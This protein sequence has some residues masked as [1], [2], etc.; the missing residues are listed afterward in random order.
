LLLL[1]RRAANAI[2][3]AGPARRYLPANFDVYLLV[4]ILVL[5]LFRKPLLWILDPL[6]FSFKFLTVA[7]L[8]AIDT[9]LRGAFEGLS[10]PF[11]GMS[12]WTPVSDAYQRFFT[13][14]HAP[15]YADTAMFL[16]FTGVVLGLEL[17]QPRFW[18]R[19]VCPLGALARLTYK[20]HPLKRRIRP[21]C[22]YC[23]RCETACHFGGTAEDDC[24]YCM[25]C[26]D[27][28]APGKISFLPGGPVLKKQARKAAPGQPGSEAPQVEDPAAVPVAAS[29]RAAYRARVGGELAGD[30]V[31]RRLLLQY[32]VGGVVAY[33]LLRLFD[34]RRELPVDFIRP[35]GVYSLGGDEAAD[36]A[37]F[38][39]LCLKCGQCLKGCTTNGLQPVLSEAGFSAL[40]TPRLIP[41]LGYCEYSCNVCGQVCPSGA[42][43]R[44][45]VEEKKRQVL[46]TAYF[47]H[48]RCIPFVTPHN[49][50]VCEEHCPT[51]DKAIK[52]REAA[53][54]YWPPDKPAWNAG[55]QAVPVR[56]LQ[57][58]VDPSLC[59]GCGICEKV[60]PL[61]GEGAVRVLR[62]P[63]G[64]AYETVYETGAAQGAGAATPPDGA[65]GGSIGG[66]YPPGG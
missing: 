20:L 28:C 41:R 48:S 5:A 43:P 24:L 62:L 12:W 60:C 17:L 32:A 2:K 21:D 65:G 8:P 29:A 56:T 37:R 38:T 1:G 11:Y 66:D 13:A 7:V 39:E 35:P 59:I 18:C 27:A 9:P 53:P 49:C 64:A 3:P 15:V 16:L 46:G 23:L 63:A 14:Y 52:L 22:S 57:P 36:E 55:E 51:S 42:I 50:T 45:S 26:I 44:L 6:V 34:G 54:P 4:L 40:W 61:P 33:P 25:E 19:Y 47:N 30:A 58:Y 10:G 31:S